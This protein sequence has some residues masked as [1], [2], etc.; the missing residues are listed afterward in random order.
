MAQ[1]R[2]RQLKSI[3]A[4]KRLEDQR[5]EIAAQRQIGLSQQLN[6]INAEIEHLEKDVAFQLKT[7]SIDLAPYLTTFVRGARSEVQRLQT[8]KS[9][10]AREA[11]EQ[12]H[13]LRAIFKRVRVLEMAKERNLQ[14]A[15]QSVE[16]AEAAHTLEDLLRH[17]APHL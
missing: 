14:R 7:A 10:V 8:K 11:S 16:A 3:E 12:E 9:Q 15:K 17:Q 2:K 6:A 1:R 5:M 4:I 13:A